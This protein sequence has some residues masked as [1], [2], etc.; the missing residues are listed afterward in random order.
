M[1]NCCA[2]RKQADAATT[3]R[4]QLAEE[5]AEIDAQLEALEER[6]AI[7]EAR[8]EELDVGLGTA[9]EKHAELDDDVIAA[10]RRLG[11]RA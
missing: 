5:L 3:R 1:S 9:Q 7:G 6:K 10:E 4:D 8:F 2:C 11:R